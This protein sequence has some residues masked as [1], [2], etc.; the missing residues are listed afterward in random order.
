MLSG[1]IKVESSQQAKFTEC[2]LP[3]N[4]APRVG[5]GFFAHLSYEP[6]I[7]I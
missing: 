6:C 1:C 3:F 4:P 2:E 7:R 5:A